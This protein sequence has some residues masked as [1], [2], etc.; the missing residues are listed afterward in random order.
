VKRRKLSLLTA[1]PIHMFVQVSVI[2]LGP[3]GCIARAKDG[4][5]G[6]SDAAKVTV[7]D[8]IGAGDCFTA[9]FLYAYL[10]VSDT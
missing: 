5:R 1:V 2:S 7:V 8:T 9:G 3:K 10:H 4:S 6:A